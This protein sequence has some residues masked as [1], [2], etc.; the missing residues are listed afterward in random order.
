MRDAKMCTNVRAA[1]A[2]TWQANSEIV[3]IKFDGDGHY[4]LT[5]NICH[6]AVQPGRSVLSHFTSV[7]NSCKMGQ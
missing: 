5:L 3:I 7:L 6:V 2:L 4:Y 1:M